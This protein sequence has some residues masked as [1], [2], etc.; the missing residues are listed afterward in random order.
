MA[1]L[2]TQDE[3]LEKRAKELSAK[4]E[5]EAKNN[6]YNSFYQS[7]TD[8]LRNEVPGLLEGAQDKLMELYVDNLR[9]NKKS[10]KGFGTKVYGVLNDYI[11][12]EVFGFQEPSKELGKRIIDDLVTAH[13]GSTASDLD[14]E[15]EEEETVSV[16]GFSVLTQEL[17]KNM[18]RHFSSAYLVPLQKKANQDAEGFRNYVSELAEKEEVSVKPESLQS[19]E[20][21]IGIYM[22]ALKAPMRK[23]MLNRSK[24]EQ[25][26]L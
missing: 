18:D 4:A 6:D 17:A 10:S 12:S 15:L 3:I 26:L 2:P 16:R 20:G 11:K 25:G 14:E 13:I 24:K 21:L 22:E 7:T 1:K 9:D 19:I 5:A 8:A 23:K